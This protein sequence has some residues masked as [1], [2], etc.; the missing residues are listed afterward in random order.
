VEDKPQLQTVLPSGP[1]FDHSYM[2]AAR[3]PQN[4]HRFALSYYANHQAHANTNISQWDHPG[5]Y[6]VDAGFD[7]EYITSWRR[8]KLVERG[9]GLKDVACPDA[10]DASLAWTP[11]KA[12]G[13]EQVY[14]GMVAEHDFIDGEAGVLFFDTTID[15]GPCE[16]GSLL[17]GYD[18]P[19]KVWVNGTEV[20]AGPGNNP[21]VP[22]ATTVAIKTNHGP[23]R[24]TIALDTNDGKAWGFYARFEP[25]A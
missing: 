13:K 25:A 24:I 9:A 4:R 6:V 1:A 7:A 15:V 16:R 5:V 17:L 10:G 19:V 18:G 3:W 11:I 21:A 23:N 8:S 22:D 14:E 20:F 12:A 2:A